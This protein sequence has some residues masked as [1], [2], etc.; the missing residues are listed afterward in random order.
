MDEHSKHEAQKKRIFF[1]TTELGLIVGK[2]TNVVSRWVSENP[3]FAL[4]LNGN[5]KICRQ[6]VERLLAGE[7]V[8]SIAGSPSKLDVD[9]ILAAAKG[10][11][12]SASDVQSKEPAPLDA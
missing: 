12:R 6:H 4:P 7:S 2:G 5:A 3:G 1:S 8:K 11:A 9:Q 10:A